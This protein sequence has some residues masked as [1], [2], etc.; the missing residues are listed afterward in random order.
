M[1]CLSLLLKLF[2]FLLRTW[3]SLLR[4]RIATLLCLCVEE[5]N[6]ENFGFSSGSGWLAGTKTTQHTHNQVREIFIFFLF[7]I[8]TIWRILHVWFTIYHHQQ[9][10]G[11]TKVLESKL[12]IA[13][14]CTEPILFV[15]EQVAF[16]AFPLAKVFLY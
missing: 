8:N 15:R 1:I 4:K 7:L 16:W 3:C 12:N 5:E 11:S 10:N 9:D 2:I 14:Y 13:I 6:N